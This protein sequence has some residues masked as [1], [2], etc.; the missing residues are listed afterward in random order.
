MPFGSTPAHAFHE[1]YVERD[2]VEG[3]SNRSFGITLGFALLFLATAISLIHG[4][5]GIKAEILGGVGLLLVVVALLHAPLLQPVN[6]LWMRFGALLASIVNPVIMFV[7]FATACAPIGL[8]M[9]ARGYDP[10]GLRILP[11][12]QTYWI[13]REL[14]GAPQ[15]MRNQF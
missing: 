10:L 12:A 8:V 15:S 3:P 1:T 4:K 13:A 11:D 2:V 7:L 14:P 5:L 9:R 6:R